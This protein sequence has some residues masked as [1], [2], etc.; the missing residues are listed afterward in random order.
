MTFVQFPFFIFQK[1]PK[2]TNKNWGKNCFVY[3]QKSHR[4]TDHDFTTG[5]LKKMK[6]VDEQKENKSSYPEFIHRD[7]TEKKIDFLF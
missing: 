7:S 6:N 1:T 5:R 4:V 3:H 2:V